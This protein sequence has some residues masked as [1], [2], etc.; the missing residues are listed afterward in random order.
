MPMYFWL[1]ILRD[2]HDVSFGSL[3]PMDLPL[4]DSDVP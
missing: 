3:Y 1:Y 2:S 4:A